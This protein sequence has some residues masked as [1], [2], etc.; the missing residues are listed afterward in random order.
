MEW[1]GDMWVKG[2]MK[3]NRQSCQHLA[4]EGSK[5]LPMGQ[6][7]SWS[8]WR[9]ERRPM[10][11]KQTEQN[12]GER[13]Q[14]TG[15]NR[16]QV[17]GGLRGHGRLNME[18]C[19]NSDQAQAMGYLNCESD[20]RSEERE[21][22]VGWGSQEKVSSVCRR[23]SIWLEVVGGHSKLQVSGIGTEAGTDMVCVCVGMCV[24]VSICVRTWVLG[25]G[26]YQ[27]K[28]Q[29]LMVGR[30]WKI[31]KQLYWKTQNIQSRACLGPDE[32]FHSEA[33]RGSRFPLSYLWI[34]DTWNPLSPVIYIPEETA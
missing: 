27:E 29:S 34:P 19:K 10:G 15:A 11:L 18:Q 31:T 32:H 7:Q 1:G 13:R 23:G 12:E 5:G 25:S 4:A 14:H 21:M 2:S 30:E 26:G 22:V 16:G 20:E 33:K 3:R 28:K 17:I 8:I 9:L 24:C 6:E